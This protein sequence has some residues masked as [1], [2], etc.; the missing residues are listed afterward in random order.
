MCLSLSEK[1]HPFYFVWNRIDRS[2]IQLFMRGIPWQ[3]YGTSPA[4][5][6]HT[7]LPVTRHKW[8]RPALPPTSKPLIVT[9]PLSSTL[10]EIQPDRLISINWPGDH[11]LY[12]HTVVSLYKRRRR[13]DLKAIKLFVDWSSRA[14]TARAC[15]C[16]AKRLQ[17][18]S[19][20]TNEIDLEWLAVGWALSRLKSTLRL[21]RAAAESSASSTAVLSVDKAADRIHRLHRNLYGHPAVR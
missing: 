6:E 18:N 21:I 13:L 4:I 19:R 11:A 9:F 15:L 10:S 12:W 17:G 8:T 2:I 20:A 5:W 1:R 14:W 7:V 16:A 3:S